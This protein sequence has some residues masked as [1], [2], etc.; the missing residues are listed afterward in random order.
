MLAV[1][2]SSINSQASSGLVAKAGSFVPRGRQLDALAAFGIAGLVDDE[3]APR[4]RP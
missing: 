1:R 3:H 2:A 4:M